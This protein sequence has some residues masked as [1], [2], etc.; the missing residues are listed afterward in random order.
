MKKLIW[1][2]I[3]NTTSMVL[4]IISRFDSK[5]EGFDWLIFIP[6][7]LIVLTLIHFFVERKTLNKLK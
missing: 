6:A 7:V 2:T 1:F 4:L 3:L 5:I